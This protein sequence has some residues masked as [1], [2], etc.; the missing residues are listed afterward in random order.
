MTKRASLI[1]PLF[2]RARPRWHMAF[3][4]EDD[5]VLQDVVKLIFSFVDRLQHQIGAA[6]RSKVEN[7]LRAFVPVF[8]MLDPKDFNTGLGASADGAIFNGDS[9][10]VSEMA[11]STFTFAVDEDTSGTYTRTGRNGKRSNGGDL[12]K[13]LLKNTTAQ[14]TRKT[15]AGTA[16]ESASSS[17]MASPSFAEDPGA[18][19]GFGGADSALMDVDKSDQP[20]QAGS[21]VDDT[22]ST[23]GKARS[24]RKGVFFANAA[25]YNL[26]RLMEIMHSRLLACKNLASKL[27]SSNS[28]TNPIA[29]ELALLNTLPAPSLKLETLRR[30]AQEDVQ[31]RDS[32]NGQGTDTSGGLNPDPAAHYYPYLLE[33]CEKLFDSE[34][35]QQTFEDIARY[36]FGTK[37]R[38]FS[39][40]SLQGYFW[41]PLM[42]LYGRNAHEDCLIE[43]LRHLSCLQSTK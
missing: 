5:N 19:N 11:S 6:E 29:F 35:D 36:M 40:T 12:R 2:A 10:N 24:V 27:A 13:R 26:L 38:H 33:C 32:F 16:S 20:I 9:F 37:V 22:S 21:S 4:V 43:Y 31:S 7:F 1:D 25:F 14:S 8:F 30:Q 41:Y 42:Q 3:I 39:Y 28:P 15:R 17:R 18:N 34:V 23:T